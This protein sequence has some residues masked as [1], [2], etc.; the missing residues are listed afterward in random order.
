MWNDSF[1]FNAI[2]LKVAVKCLSL[3]LFLIGFL[4]IVKGYQHM[5]A[6]ICWGMKV[7]E[8]FQMEY[9]NLK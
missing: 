6:C 1:M 4:N 5:K 2:N 7:L 3:N 9:E 8:D